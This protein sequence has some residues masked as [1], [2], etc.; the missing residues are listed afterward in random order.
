[1][2]KGLY[3]LVASAFIF[4]GCNEK[5]EN[6]ISTNDQEV[7]KIKLAKDTITMNEPLRCIVYL[8]K[9][10]FENKDSEIMVFLESNENNPLE[11]DLSNEYDI[12]MEV[13]VNLKLDTINQK[14][15]TED[16]YP[17]KTT[18]AFGRTFSSPGKKKIRGYVL[19]YYDQNPQTLIDS[20]IEE[21]KIRRYYFE[22]EIY[23]SK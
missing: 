5:K 6:R 16:K 1:M 9:P 15:F 22:K 12:P 17:Y 18:A 10:F 2:K 23:V 3:W 13:F 21:D 7:L 4:I 11:K 8:K 20:V 19:E 14:W